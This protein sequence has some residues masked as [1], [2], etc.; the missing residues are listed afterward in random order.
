MKRML[1]TVAVL[2]CAISVQ[3]DAQTS[4]GHKPHPHR[5]ARNTSHTVIYDKDSPNPAIGWHW[6]NGARVCHNDCDNDEIPGSG[7]TCMDV[8][9]TM[10]QCSRQN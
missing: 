3:A 6:E 9:Q 8:G 10:R 7:Y 5:I 2:C 1:L 4:S